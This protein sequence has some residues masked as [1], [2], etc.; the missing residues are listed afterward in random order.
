[1]KKITLIIV[2]LI[3]IC[4]IKAQ[5]DS[6]TK[7]IVLSA[8]LLDSLNINP[9]LEL[10]GI[11]RYLE[12]NCL[13]N[14]FA[15]IE[16]KIWKKCIKI[17]SQGA[18]EIEIVFQKFLLSPN[19]IISFYTDSLQ[20]QYQGEYFVHKPDS[21]Y[22]SNFLRGDHCKIEIEIPLDELENNQIQISQIH[23]L[24]ESFED[25]IRADYS[26]MI[27]VNCSEGNNWCDEKR[28]VAIFYFTEKGGRYKCT[29]AL[30]NNYRDNYEQYFL[31]ARHCTESITDWQTTAFYFNHQHAYCNDTDQNEYYEMDLKK[32]FKVQGS[33][34]I[35]Y[36]DVS[37]SDNAL[38]LITEPI[39][40]QF[41][42]FYAGVDIKKKSMGDKVTCIHHSK[43]KPKKI[44]SGKLKHFA[45]P[46][47]EMYWDDGIVST[48]GSGAPVFYNN[49]KRVIGTISGGFDLDCSNNLKQDWVGKIRSCVDYSS[50]INNALFG[51]NPHYISYYGIDP[52]QECQST[53]NLW[54]AFHSTQEYDAALNGLTIQA[55][56]T[57][58]VS[59]AI[60]HSGANFTIT[61]GDKI[62][63]LPGTRIHSGATVTAKILPCSYN[64][65]SCGT[66]SSILKSV[67]DS[68]Q[69]YNE[70]DD[71]D[72]IY[73]E[74]QR[75]NYK[76][77]IFPNPNPGT[78]KIETNFPLTEVANLKIIN[79]L[80]V[81]IYETQRVVSNE[82]Q[83]Q[84]F[85][86]G[87]H[88]VV[89]L[90]KDGTMFTQKVMVQR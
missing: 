1:M 78:F 67:E 20:Y 6:F 83:L 40:I 68:Q 46:K 89:M 81:T 51:T 10:C 39:P 37:W 52:I 14:E 66:H 29:G 47:W 73:L 85:D 13:D 65:E 30:V 55:G 48:G 15:Q 21:S 74:N 38:L 34:L 59:N 25:A 19:T 22:I 77:T 35:G 5:E 61:A 87:L 82:I 42:V 16:D 58:I 32:Y 72:V 12:L 24:T 62:V 50:G 75:N 70:N 88:F 28:S 54:G 86:S 8:P 43:G 11:V 64:L 4:A 41:N 17:Q 45:G 9:Y 7:N 63:F 80:S 31:T 27:N 90:L 23:H 71:Y 76:I 36:C 33:R 26:C 84:N 2:L 79:L 49:N 44:V 57:I 60:F 69:E 53:L 18:R 56:N 3:S